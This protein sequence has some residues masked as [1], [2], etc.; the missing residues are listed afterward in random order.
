MSNQ[1]FHSCRELYNTFKGKEVWISGSDPSLSDYPEN[2]FDD[3]I[4][5]TLHLSYLKFP[6]ATFRYS[7]EYD[8]TTFLLDKDPLYK[9]KPL[10]AACPMFGKTMGQTKALLKD[11]KEVYFHRMVSYPPFGLRGKISESY[12]RQKILQTMKNRAHIWGGH[13]SCLHTC[14][15]MA[16]LLGASA[17]HL[18]GCGHNLYSKDGLE[19]YQMVE[20][21]HHIMR[22]NYRSFTDPVKNAILIEQTSL[23]GRLCEENGIKFHWHKQWCESMDSYITFSQEWFQEQRKKAERKFPLYK[24]AYWKFVKGPL[25]NIITRL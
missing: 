8:R 18:I 20:K 21:D 13:G 11:N 16:V 14:M 7:S 12:T 3:K 23:F 10:I 15:Y 24:R 6:N 22:P 5:I 9:T 25:L 17:I 4:A 2:F 1:N 19:H